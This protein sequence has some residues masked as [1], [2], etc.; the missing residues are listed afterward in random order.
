MASAAGDPSEVLCANMLEGCAK[1]KALLLKLKA[2]LLRDKAAVRLQAAARGFLA[3]QR[4]R[5]LRGSKR[6]DCTCLH[7]LEV[8]A[9]LHQIGT[10]VAICWEPLAVV[11][12]K[13]NIAGG[14]VLAVRHII[15]RRRAI[16]RGAAL[17]TIRTKPP[18][19][20][21]LHVSRFVCSW[22]W[23]W[24]AAGKFGGFPWDPGETSITCRSELLGD[25]EGLEPWPPPDH[26]SSRASCLR[27]REE[28]S[29]A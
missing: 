19:V 27:R 25:Y 18:V 17:T 20:F 11:P 4:A 13:D 10:P 6:T 14:L 16:T 7:P 5:L 21:L 26:H 8:A 15:L 12:R 23:L 24:M 9:P 22:S 3:R 28:M 2:S 1:L 29:C